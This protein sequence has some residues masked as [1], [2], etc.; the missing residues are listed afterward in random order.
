MAIFPN[1][2]PD[3][4]YKRKAQSG[5]EIRSATSGKEWRRKSWPRNKQSFEMAWAMLTDAEAATLRAFY[6]ARQ[7]QWE[8]FT[9]FDFASRNWTAL[10]CDEEGTGT[11]TTFTIPGKT[12]SA[13]IVYVDGVLEAGANWAIGVGTGTEG[14]D[15]IVFDG[16][17]E[18]ASGSIVTITFTGKRRYTARFEGDM[19]E[20]TTEFG[21]S[22]SATVVEVL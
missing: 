20:T 11:L 19:E 1:I 13:Q 21:P 3:Y 10:E 4:N 12:T 9:F 17:H 18:P 8:S 6:D 2:T 14:E 16:G 7:G 5:T 22:L 15:Q